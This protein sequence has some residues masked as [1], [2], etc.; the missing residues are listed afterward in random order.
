M[1]KRIVITTY[2]TLGDLYPYIALAI[3]LKQRGHKVVIATSKL[4]SSKVEAEDI[5]FHAIRPNFEPGLSTEALRKAT[6]SK[7]GLKYLICELILPHIKDTY[8]DLIQVVHGADLLVTQHLSFA[9]PI[10]AEKAG[11][12]WISGVLAPIMIPS[13]YDSLVLSEPHNQ[14][15]SQLFNPLVNSSIINLSK[16][17]LSSWS[18]PIK[19]LRRDLGLRQVKDPLFEGNHSPE[20][21]LALF[22]KVFAQPQSDWPKRTCVAGFPFYDRQGEAELSLELLEFLRTGSP[23][24]VFTLGS[25]LVR[26]A[27]NFYVESAIAVR[28]LGCRAVLLMGEDRCNL[29][30]EFLSENIVAFDYAPYSKLFLHSQAIVHQGGIGTT[31]E[32]LRSGR[33]M[34]VMPYSHDQPNNAARVERLGVGLTI[35]RGEYNATNVVAK[36]HQLLNEPSFARQ[37]AEVGQQIQLENGV[38]VACDAIEAQLSYS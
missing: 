6:D 36:L 34:L 11:I 28:Q 23:P 35:S 9:G 15:K 2:G 3:E 29:P 24:I 18:D 8:S 25:A 4:Y 5:E 13:A 10:V 12:K 17:F 33:P 16:Y 37:S 1:N 20:L 19:Q 30:Q 26:N 14:I 21:V 31:A 32:A 38:R 27:G 22:S 7:E